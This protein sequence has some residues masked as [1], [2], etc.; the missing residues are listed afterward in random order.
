MPVLPTV[1]LR[2]RGKLF[3]NNELICCQLRPVINM[4]L[5]MVVIYK[6]ETIHSSRITSGGG[7]STSSYFLVD[8]QM[9]L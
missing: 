2:L 5:T 8:L 1:N 7:G 3:E 9:E 6:G 4:Q